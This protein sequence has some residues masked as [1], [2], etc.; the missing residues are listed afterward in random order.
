M[1]PV[2]EGVRA[3]VEHFD[4][5][6][7]VLLKRDGDARQHVPGLTGVAGIGKCGAG[8]RQR[9]T[10][11]NKASHGLPHADLNDANSPG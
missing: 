2:L 9:D 7:L 4:R 6:R 11:C 8:C 1:S 3:G 10:G 5:R